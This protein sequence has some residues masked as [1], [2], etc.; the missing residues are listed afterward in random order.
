MRK[1]ILSALAGASLFSLGLSQANAHGAWIAERWGELAVIYGHGAGDDPYDP[2]K[3]TSVTAISEDGTATPVPLKAQESHATLDISGHPAALALTFDNGF[4]AQDSDGK[5]VNKPKNEVPGATSGSHT[6][7]YN[8][9]L[10][11]IDGDIPALPEQ[12]L[13]IVPLQNP[14]GLKAGDTYRVRV[15]F[16]GKPLEGA[17]LQLDYVNLDSLK[18]GP[19]DANGEIEIELRNEGLN[20]IAVDHDVKLEGDPQAD[21]I[22]YTATLSFVAEAHSHD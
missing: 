2:A 16:E 8:L 4:W 12:K 7:K 20:V 6:I 14:Q 18:S 17:E 22:G 9:T 3:I 19:A 15:L 21:E 10:N 13:Q 11:H 1:L 5:W